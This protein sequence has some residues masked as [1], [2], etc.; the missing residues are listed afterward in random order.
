M[1]FMQ[2]LLRQQQDIWKGM[3]TARRVVVA[4]VGLLFLAVL[5]GVSYYAQQADYRAL[6][7]GLPVEEVG[8][9]TAKLDSRGITYRLAAGGPTILVPADQVQ[10]ARVSLAAEGLPS[11]GGKGFEL[12]DESPLGM[13]PFVQNLNYSRA[14]QAELARSIMQIEPV[15][16]AKVLIVRPEQSPFLREQKPATASVV[17]QLKPGTALTRGVAASITALVSRSVEGLSP[18]NVALVDSKGRTLSEQRGP[19]G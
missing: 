10:Q 13:T 4:G 6:F 11:R 7:S 18:E 19:D 9:L 5:A 12:F 2:R 3:S 1:N 14:L 16:F 17:L 8:A 15:S